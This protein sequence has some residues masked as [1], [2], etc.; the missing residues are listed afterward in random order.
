MFMDLKKN[1]ALLMFLV[2]LMIGCENLRSE[3]DKGNKYYNFKK[4]YDAL[5][6][7]KSAAQKFPINGER[8]W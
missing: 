8:T 3:I 6:Q 7:Y 2:C 4:Y 5:Q 1:T